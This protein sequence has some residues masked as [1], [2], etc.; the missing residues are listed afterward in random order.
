MIAEDYFTTTETTGSAGGAA[1]RLNRNLSSVVSTIR[2][3]GPAVAGHIHC[4]PDDR[5]NDDGCEDVAELHTH[6]TPQPFA[7]W[8][9]VQA[10]PARAV[11]VKAAAVLV[12]V[13]GGAAWLMS[14]GSQVVD[15]YELSPEA[16]PAAAAG[17]AVVEG[18]EAQT[19]MP[20]RAPAGLLLPDVRG[21]GPDTQVSGVTGLAAIETRQQ[22]VM[23][24]LD[25]LAAAI[26]TLQS[27]F[28]RDREDRLVSDITRQTEQDLQ[29]QDM[30]AQLAG[31]QKQLA[32]EKVA[33]PPPVA[34]PVGPVMPSPAEGDWVVNVASST[35][36]KSIRKLQETLARKDIVTDIQPVSTRGELRYR[37]RVTGFNSRDEARRQA[38]VLALEEGLGGAWASKR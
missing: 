31:L 37:L 25:T 10:I 38:K 19:I 34:A 23:D 27:R 7:R 12:I 3:E 15:N 1:D 17:M 5:L 11:L 36:Q 22:A 14:G 33:L 20:R 6:E 16:P 26:E 4:L 24:R 30:Q 13:I 2:D 18:G 8:W 35:Q 21:L 28:E 9:E 32:V 29:L